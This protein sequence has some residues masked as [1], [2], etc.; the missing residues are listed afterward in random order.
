M[1]GADLEGRGWEEAG[2]QGWGGQPGR[3]KPGD[4][5]GSR[6]AR[7]Q[8]A[9]GFPGM[10]RGDLGTR[11]LLPTTHV[12]PRDWRSTVNQRNSHILGAVNTAFGAPATGR[13]SLT[14]G[15]AQA[16][17]FPGPHSSAPQHPTATA[18]LAQRNHQVWLLAPSYGEH[19]LLPCYLGVASEIHQH[20]RLSLSCA[21]RGPCE[22]DSRV[23]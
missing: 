23:S 12:W 4:G 15:G 10:A 17:S 1:E 7:A 5:D 8:R 21:S 14:D 11:R 6:T 2:K 19:T 20:M 13:T 22:Q 9:Q 3:R 18:V 16:V